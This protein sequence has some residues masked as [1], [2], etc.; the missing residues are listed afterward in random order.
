MSDFLKLENGETLFV[1]DS[2]EVLNGRADYTKML[3]D[4][5]TKELVT[6]MLNSDIWKEAE[7]SELT[8]VCA[9]KGVETNIVTSGFLFIGVRL[10]E[11]DIRD[12]IISKYPEKFI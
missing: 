1:F 9:Q 11:P 12:N 5:L 3:K 4:Q 10:C 7:N 6:V 2:R 8:F